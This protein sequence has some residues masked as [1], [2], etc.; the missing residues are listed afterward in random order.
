MATV[1]F[2]AW[3]GQSAPIEIAA[4]IYQSTTTTINF[5]VLDADRNAVDLTGY[6][7]KFAARYV[8]D[9]TAAVSKTGS[10]VVAASGTCKIELSASDMDENGECIGS[11]NLYSGG[12]VAGAVTDRVLFRFEIQEAID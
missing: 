8:D 9:N 1:A 4:Q 3:L 11:L 10:I 12:N 2:E 7:L 6:A 5:T